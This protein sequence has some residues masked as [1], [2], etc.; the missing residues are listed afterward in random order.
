[1]TL[2]DETLKK[3]ELDAKVLMSTS[4]AAWTVG[5]DDPFTAE[6]FEPPAS[7]KQLPLM[8]MVRGQFPDAFKDKDRPAWPVPQTPGVRPE[9]PKDDEAEAE[10]ITPA[11]G[12][13]ILMGCSQ[14]FRKNFLQESNLDLF[15]NSVDAVTLDSAL[16]NLRGKKPIE[17][18]ITKPSDTARAVWKFVNYGAVNLAI[19][20]AGIAVLV[21]RRRGRKAY[22]AAYQAARQAG[23]SRVALT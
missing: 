6:A 21:I 12:Q 18:T 17:R 15:L 16:V 1:M 10:P 20:G 11:E 5:K 9:P 3:N 2:D 14:M 4:D 22:L 7:G 13:L 23:R 19:A 8:A